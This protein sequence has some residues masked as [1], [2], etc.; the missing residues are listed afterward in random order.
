[1]NTKEEVINKLIADND[2]KSYLEIGVQF[3]ESIKRIA[4]DVRHGVD[5]V[6]LL[7]NTAYC[8]AFFA[9]KS[10][11]FFRDK[12]GLDEYDIIFVDGLHHADQVLAD[13][14]NSIDR[15]S[16]GGAIVVHDL[17]PVDELEQ[18]VPR[19]SQSWVGDCWKTWYLLLQGNYDMELTSYDFDHGVGVI[20][21]ID[22]DSIDDLFCD[23]TSLLSDLDLLS[24]G[25]DFE[26]YKKLLCQ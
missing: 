22:D 24:Y 13:I 9:M 12:N 8:D 5:P 18:T 10:D 6:N 1:M 2:Y 14:V 21:N 3:G 25:Q 17:L 15:L 19:R 23:F 4:V 26:N 7:R 20:S 11:D 16:E